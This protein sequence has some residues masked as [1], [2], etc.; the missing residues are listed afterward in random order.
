MDAR[1]VS[2]EFIVLEKWT[3]T[4][5]SPSFMGARNLVLFE[6]WTFTVKSTSFMGREARNRRVGS[7]G[8]VDFYCKKYQFQA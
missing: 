7:V 3:F 6:K 4:V 5:K 8:K 2:A 1:R